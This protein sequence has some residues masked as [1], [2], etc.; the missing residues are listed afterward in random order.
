MRPLPAHLADKLIAP[1]Q[2]PP[3][4]WRTE[5]FRDAFTAQHIGRVSRAYR[6]H[7]H[8]HTVYGPDGITQTLLGQWLGLSQPQISRIEG[9]APIRNL[10][11]LVY[12]HGYCG[13]RQSCCGSR[14][15]TTRASSLPWNHYHPVRC[16]PR[17]PARAG[18]AFQHRRPTRCPYRR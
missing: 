5:Q 1:P 2:V 18:A 6:T 13:S 9:G 4:F 15:P 10:D 14:F 17:P 7:S 12:W 11:T 16:L 3:E 8:H